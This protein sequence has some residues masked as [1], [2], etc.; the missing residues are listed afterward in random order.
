[1]EMV[2]GAIKAAE[3]EQSPIILQIAEGRLIHS[4]LELIGPMMI[5]AAAKSKVDIAVHFDHG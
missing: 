3:E 4:P 2:R 5:N 1:M